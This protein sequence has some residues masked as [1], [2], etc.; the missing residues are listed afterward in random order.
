[1]YLADQQWTFN[2]AGYPDT[3]VGQKLF[4]VE[5]AWNG[6]GMN[7]IQERFC[8]QHV[9]G[10]QICRQAAIDGKVYQSVRVAGCYIAVGEIAG[11]ALH[12]GYRNEY[13]GSGFC[14]IID[15]CR[16]PLECADDGRQLFG[17]DLVI[18][19]PFGLGW[20]VKWSIVEQTYEKEKG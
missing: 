2:P 12:A 11:G 10:F 9:T 4:E 13:T 17:V 18:Y 5:T 15:N 16:R 20:F 8:H 14:L 3:L 19:V 1:M 6:I 7:P